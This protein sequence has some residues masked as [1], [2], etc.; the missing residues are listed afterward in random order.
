MMRASLGASLAD[1]MIDESRLVQPEMGMTSAALWTFIP[2][3]RLMGKDDWLPESHQ[4][5]YYTGNLL[6]NIIINRTV[7]KKNIF[8]LN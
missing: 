2:S 5:K 7:T 3:T 1:Q 4:Y 6:C 8:F